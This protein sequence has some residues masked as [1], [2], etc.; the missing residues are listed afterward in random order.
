MTTPDPLTHRRTYRV[1]EVSRMLGVP[2]PT[3]YRW[4]LRGRLAARQVGRVL[5]IPADAVDRLLTHSRT[6]KSAR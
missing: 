6:K 4:V 2:K 5:L 1:A 3:I